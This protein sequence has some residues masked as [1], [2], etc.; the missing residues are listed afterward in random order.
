MTYWHASRFL[1]YSTRRALRWALLMDLSFL[2]SCPSAIMHRVLVKQ[3][4]VM[5]QYLRARRIFFCS[6]T[7]SSG[8]SPHQKVTSRVKRVLGHQ[9]RCAAKGRLRHSNIMVMMLH[10]RTIMRGVV[11]LFRRHPTEKAFF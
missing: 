4:H 11:S 10:I 6:R 9:L 5:F 8:S 1:K 7:I 2:H 3:C